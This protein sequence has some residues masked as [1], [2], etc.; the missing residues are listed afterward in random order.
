MNEVGQGVGS[1]VLLFCDYLGKEV[2]FGKTC[3]EGRIKGLDGIDFKAFGD[4]WFG[5]VCVREN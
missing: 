2:T 4:V 1:L 3:I 5:N